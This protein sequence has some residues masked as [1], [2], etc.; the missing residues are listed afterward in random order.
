MNW[1]RKKFSVLVIPDDGSRTLKFKLSHHMLLGIGSAVAFALCMVFI[2][3]F[4]L[5]KALYWKHTAQML[6]HDNERLYADVARV[7]ELAQVVTR[8]KVEEQT[9][10]SILAGHIGPSPIPDEAQHIEG[11]YEI[12]TLLVPNKPRD[13]LDM[14]WVPAI[15]PVSPSV[16][17]VARA[18][19]A[20]DNC[21]SGLS[22][23]GIFKKRHS[24]IDIVAIAGTPVQA[25]A[26]GQVTFS[27]FDPELG[28]MV[29]IDH[30]GIYTTRYGHNRALLVKEGE[31]VK[32]GQYIALVGTSTQIREPYL[33]Y[34]VIEGGRACNPHDFL[35][36]K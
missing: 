32:Q 11:Y 3:L 1:Q 24:G 6:E 4:F 19:G 23:T 22:P 27:D 5:W 18:F 35:P 34:E 14:Y 20:N 8:M 28:Y 33:H 10:R 7:D 12:S 30:G 26:N 9:L 2:G 21:I 25:T 16:G 13:D 36:R 17:W 15:W 29:V 31:Y